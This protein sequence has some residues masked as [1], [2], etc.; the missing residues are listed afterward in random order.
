VRFKTIMGGGYKLDHPLTGD[1]VSQAEA[2]RHEEVDLFSEQ[3]DDFV[4]T[5]ETLLDTGFVDFTI[6]LEGAGVADLRAPLYFAVVDAYGT[7]VPQWNAGGESYAP[8]PEDAHAYARTIEQEFLRFLQA[9]GG[10]PT[11]LADTLRIEVE[12][13][14]H[15]WG[16][17]APSLQLSPDDK[18][19]GD[20]LVAML[21][22]V[23]KTNDPPRNVMREAVGWFLRKADVFADNFASSAGKAAGTAAGVLAVGAGAAMVAGCDDLR[24]AA[25]A[26]VHVLS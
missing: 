11:E 5:R 24:A 26:V 20:A 6:S 22:E 25:A 15:T 2:A 18:R 4:V 14:V 19:T 10:R 23:V 9:L 12:V 21:S 7:A 3:K 8:H 16:R 1:L 13:F 17:V